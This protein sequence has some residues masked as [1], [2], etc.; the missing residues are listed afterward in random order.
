MHAY[1][2]TRACSYVCVHIVAYCMPFRVY[3][4]K[5]ENKATIGAQITFIARDTHF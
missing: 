4:Y 5:A 2:Y 1:I 3:T